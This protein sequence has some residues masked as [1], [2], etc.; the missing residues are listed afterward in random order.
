MTLV[1]HVSFD[2]FFYLQKILLIIFYFFNKNYFRVILECN[3]T[4]AARFRANQMEKE[5]S[6]AEDNDKMERISYE[7]GIVAIVAE[8]NWG[9]FWHR[10]RC[11]FSLPTMADGSQSLD[12]YN[13]FYV[14][15]FT[16]T[17]SHR[18]ERSV[19]QPESAANCWPH[20]RDRSDISK[21]N[22]S[23]LSW[24]IFKWD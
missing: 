7:N 14:R 5:E 17:R 3:K 8:E 24:G 20:K 16:S 23:V 12:F 2:L 10:C 1:V 13:N 21:H 19:V 9:K 15:H 6:L 18:T 22:R 4:P 11:L